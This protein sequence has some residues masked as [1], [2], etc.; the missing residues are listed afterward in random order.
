M[1]LK[2]RHI[3]PTA[4]I[5]LWAIAC[6]CF[7]QFC[8]PYHFFYKEQNQLFLLTADWLRTYFDEAGSFLRWCLPCSPPSPIYG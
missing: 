6:F 7:F 3:I 8:Y 4:A 1:K 5:V 2:G